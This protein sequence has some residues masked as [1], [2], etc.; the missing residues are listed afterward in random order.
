ME[1]LEIS[2]EL[3]AQYGINEFQV[4]LIIEDSLQEYY[5]LIYPPKLLSGNKLL[6]SKPKNGKLYS[7]IILISK[8]NISRI[9][10]F[11]DTNVSKFAI[12]ERVN[13]IKRSL[14]T[15]F[16]EQSTAYGKVVDKDANNYIVELYEPSN[17]KEIRPIKKI[18][19]FIN[20]KK[21]LSQDFMKLKIGNIFLFYVKIGSLSHHSSDL[22]L[23]ELERKNHKFLK[24]IATTA[25]KKANKRFEQN[26]EIRQIKINYNLDLL[27]I[28]IKH[29]KE[30][31]I[32]AKLRS[33]II[34]SIKKI[35]GFSTNLKLV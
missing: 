8:P 25:I 32:N 16:K 1:L 21:L 7:R 27:T 3:S 11:L 26:L 29:N 20:K 18:V 31:R 33:Y 23:V 12:N 14:H 9:L 24:Y 13:N 10:K 19:G 28:E 35:V 22:F 17:K 30:N 6:V 4:Q 15:V 5:E 2:R 34:I